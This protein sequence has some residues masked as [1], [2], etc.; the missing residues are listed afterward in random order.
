MVHGT[1]RLFDPDDEAARRL[2]QA[3]RDMA[4]RYGGAALDQLAYAWILAHPSRPVPVIGTNKLNR[5]EQAAAA[6][7][8]G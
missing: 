1:W 2:A 6:R 8:P 3:A 7:P 5:L 4:D